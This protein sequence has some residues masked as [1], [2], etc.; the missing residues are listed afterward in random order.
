MTGHP[1]DQ[2]LRVEGFKKGFR[3]LS[4]DLVF[5]VIFLKKVLRYN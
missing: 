4:L 2:G 5:K 3:L 1:P